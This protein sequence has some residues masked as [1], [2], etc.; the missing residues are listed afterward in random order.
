MSGIAGVWMMNGDPAFRHRL[1]AMLEV[2]AHRGPDGSAIWA[3]DTVAMGHAMLRSTP[4]SVSEVLPLR[5]PDQCVVLTSDARIDNRRELIGRLGLGAGER[6]DLADSELI[7][8]A[9]RRWGADCPGQL[10]GDFA[11][12][13]WDGERRQ[14]FCARDHFGVRPFHYHLRAGQ[15]FAFASELKS[16]ETVPGV[17]DE[18]NEWWIAR[19]LSLGGEELTAT[20][21]E[22]ALRLPPAH[23]LT[24]TRDRAVLSR[25]W[26]L[27]PDL[28]VRRDSSRDYEEEFREIFVEAIRCRTRSVTPVASTLSGGLDSSS[29][30]CV[31]AEVLRDEGRDPLHAISLVFDATPESDERPYIEAVLAGGGMVPHFVGMSE[32]PPVEAACA[33][34]P[35][36]DGPMS[37]ANIALDFGL[38]SAA[39]Q[40]GCGVLLDG[41][42]G[43][44]AISH[45][46][47]NF[48]ALVRERRFYRAAV[49]GF[50]YSRNH[51]EPLG[52]VLRRLLL[53]PVT[54]APV[55]RAW[56][57]I[58]RGK[59]RRSSRSITGLY[60]SLISRD[61]Q[62]RMQELRRK[63]EHPAR[64]PQ[65]PPAQRSHYDAFVNPFTTI[66]LETD[67]LVAAAYGIEKRYPFLDLRLIQFAYGLPS[68]EKVM[69]GWSRSI[70]RRS[71]SATV[72]GMVSWRTDK[73][74]LSHWLMHA[75]SGV[76]EE[77]LRQMVDDH[78]GE[79]RP[80]V[81][82][83][84]LRDTLDEAIEHR[85]SI[86]F[87]AAWQ[88][89]SLGL[90]LSG[91]RS[92]SLRMP[93]ED[94]GIALPVAPVYLPS[95]VRSAG[96]LH[97][98]S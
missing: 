16:L 57:R 37:T 66:A 54:P 9:Y 58:R 78:G 55:L 34:G 24:V 97:T 84:R 44:D 47:E 4:K 21:Y 30:A 96:A 88:S 77:R 22:K 6:P 60:D 42:F 18:L 56:S 92:G 73:G 5:D 43:D 8:A 50:Q 20:V 53:G 63:D 95:A 90:W 2:M 23:T 12:A 89:L 48:A 72:P 80:Y 14:M 51:H 74:D 86:R 67:D 7:L 1:A 52:W 69:G 91:R 40:A 46:Q 85:C 32:L 71:L 26:S 82:L 70:L 45:G 76:D 35:A 38:A 68:A 94:G 75:V 81:N 13:I 64:D 29:I 36:L 31:A 19:Y 25:Y 87:V 15:C 39:R 49:S 62:A 27:D 59:G 83:E 10:L 93:L 61:F 3:E 65:R 98:T 33:F 11:F 28:E 79:L 17:A 41:F